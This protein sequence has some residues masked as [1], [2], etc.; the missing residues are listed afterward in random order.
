MN[1]GTGLSYHPF[2]GVVYNSRSIFDF[3]YFM[4]RLHDH[5]QLS[6]LDTCGFCASTCPTITWWAEL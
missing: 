3:G 2:T 6:I 4:A 5:K 1:E